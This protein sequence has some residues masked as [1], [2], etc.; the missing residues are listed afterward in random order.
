MKPDFVIIGAMKCATSTLHDQLDGVAGV[1]MSE[2]K[3]PNFFSDAENWSKGADWYTSLF[4]KM[5]P[6]A[7]KGESSTHYTK[8]PTYPECAKRLAEYLP[9]AKL[10]YVMRDPIDRIVSQYIHEWS[11]HVIDKDCDINLAIEAHPMLVDYSKYAMQLDPYIQAFGHKRILPIFF[12][13][14]MLNP[15]Q[16]FERVGKFL[17]IQSKMVWNT[18]LAKN[19]SSQRQRRHPVLNSFLAVPV[20]QKIRRGL[21]PESFRERVRSRWTLQARPEL[22]PS[23]IAWLHEKL[24]PDLARLGSMLGLKLCCATYKDR[25][26][27]GSAPDWQLQV[28]A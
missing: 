5:P 9:D 7:L 11:Q 3:E 4:E 10:I 14:L 18:E 6:D 2:P 8:L 17:G 15:Q 1:S 20:L 21:L 23:K 28:N 22:Q 13:R 26:L 19:V 12:E 16:E 25:V 24:D 27:S